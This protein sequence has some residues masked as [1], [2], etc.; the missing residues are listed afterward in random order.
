MKNLDIATFKQ[1]LLILKK[2]WYYNSEKIK[3]LEKEV[4][5]FN[6]F[7]FEYFKACKTVE[8]I[9]DVIFERKLDKTYLPIIT[10][11]DEKFTHHIPI[12]S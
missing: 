5:I 10:F 3:E 2:E 6:E 4:N 8:E 1:L 12:H 9:M 11:I 7:L